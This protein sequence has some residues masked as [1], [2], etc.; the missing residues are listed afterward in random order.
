MS[1]QAD[2]ASAKDTIARIRMMESQLGARIAL[3]HDTEWVTE[4]KDSVLLEML[5]E[6]MK[7]T[8]KSKILTGEV[9]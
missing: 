3:A 1:L 8:A 9:L 6:E 2:H 4:G 5:D 7:H